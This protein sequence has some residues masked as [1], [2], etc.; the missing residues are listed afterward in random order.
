MLVFVPLT[1]SQLTR[2]AEGGS[3]E[4]GLAFAVTSSLRRA[5]GFTAADDEDG[6]HTALHI[7]GLAG[8]L[9]LRTRLVA[10]VE[11]SG[12]LVAGS[13]FGE[14][15]VGPLPWSAVTALFGD[16]APD[17]AAVLRERLTGRS[18]VTAWDEDAVA[19]FLAEHELLW[20]GPG[21]WSALV[22][23]LADDCAGDQ[24]L[25]SAD[26]EPDSPTG[27]VSTFVRA[28]LDLRATEDGG[29]KRAW[30]SPTPSFLFLIGDVQVGAD[31]Q[32]DD[33]L[34]LN[35]GEISR[36][37]ALRFW[38]PVARE[39]ATPGRTFI[40]IYGDREIGAGTI[41]QPAEPRLR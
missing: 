10:V 36:P 23:P 30:E 27:F 40:L 33:R 35:P 26:E 15:R 25:R 21:E 12:E 3:L 18:L 38:A 34:P 9:Y 1:A 2:W 13:E 41:G 20:H 6:E 14:V 11:A 4:P 22:G 39:L 29:L 19:D 32:T 5:F 8:L 7:A 28:S 16:D 17:A 37:V 31:I 24:A